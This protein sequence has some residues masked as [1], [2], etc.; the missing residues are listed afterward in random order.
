EDDEEDQAL[1][2]LRRG[3]DVATINGEGSGTGEKDEKT[4]RDEIRK[5]P[6]FWG[7]FKYRPILGIVPIGGGEEDEDDD[8]DD[9]DDAV[10]E[11]DGEGMGRRKG[12]EVALVERPMFDVD[13]PERFYGDQEWGERKDADVRL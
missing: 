10:V 2:R 3:E 12:V 8:N 5:G 7:T 1:V 13:L 9:D 4:Q 11:T 6:P